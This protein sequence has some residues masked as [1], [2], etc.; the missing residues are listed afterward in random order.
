[1]SESVVVEREKLDNEQKQAVAARAWAALCD[2]LTAAGGNRMDA[3]GVTAI[4]LAHCAEKFAPNSSVCLSI[5]SAAALALLGAAES[6]LVELAA[7]APQG[8]A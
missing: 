8:R 5:I 2:E 1:M 7:A 6:Q 3:P 4:L